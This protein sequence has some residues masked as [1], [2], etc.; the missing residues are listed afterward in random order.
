M[1]CIALIMGMHFINIKNSNTAVSF[2][3]ITT[4][5]LTFNLFDIRICTSGLPYTRRLIKEVREEF[6]RINY[7]TKHLKI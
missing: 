6:W 7:L 2:Q 3:N 1:V 4:T 5:E